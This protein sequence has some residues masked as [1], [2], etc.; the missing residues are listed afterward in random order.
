M[1]EVE[2]SQHTNMARCLCDEDNTEDE[3]YSYYF[4][5]NYDGPFDGSDVFF[6][7]GSDCSNTSVAL[8]QCAELAS[9]NI[10]S[11][12]NETKYIPIPVNYLVDPESGTCSEKNSGSSTFY[13]FSSLE[14]RDTLWSET[15]S[16]DTRGPAPRSEISASSGE[17]AVTVHWNNDDADEEGIQYFN[18]LCMRE[19]TPAEVADSS[20]AN[21][22]DTED[23]C[24]KVLEYDDTTDATK[25][26]IYPDNNDDYQV[27]DDYDNDRFYFDEQEQFD[28]KP[29]RKKH[30][31][32][33]LNYTC[34]DNMLVEGGRPYKCY[35]CGSTTNTGKKM[36]I[37]GLE[38]QVE[39]SFA[40]VA[41]DEY[42]N[43]SVI[44]EV[45]SETPLPTTDFA[46][47]YS[48]NGGSATGDYCFV[49]TTVYRSKNH[50]FVKIL[51]KFRDK[52]L[53]T[54]E[55]GIAFTKWYYANGKTIAS[56]ISSSNILVESVKLL[57]LPL[58][59]LASVLLFLPWWSL[60]LISGAAVAFKKRQLIK[61]KLR[62]IHR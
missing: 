8:S 13:I 42:K 6:Y 51:R 62:S 46:E 33:D 56:F 7:L 41:V 27:N 4:A 40:V 38:N 45:V 36:R 47:H 43:V 5:F 21:W 54:N 44:S 9:L 23:V 15:I 2:Y 22:V 52:K 24:G 60:F 34:P 10:N 29:N 11:F 48:S 1:D 3:L 30:Y 28:H 19:T 25:K 59:L 35:V 55:P 20:M 50:P 31:K 37:G 61:G 17:N 49:A 39:Y 18:V 32:N 53:L 57:L 26:M 12:N 58:V 14:N 16:Y